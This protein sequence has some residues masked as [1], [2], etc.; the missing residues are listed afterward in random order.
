[1]PGF[2]YSTIAGCAVLATLIAIHLGIRVVIATALVLYALTPFL[3][4][5][6]KKPRYKSGVKTPFSVGGD[7]CLPVQCVLKQA[8]KT[9]FATHCSV[10]TK[11]IGGRGENFRRPGW[12]RPHRPKK[13]LS[14][15]FY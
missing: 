6:K 13:Q 9:G 1:M 15:C 5:R 3:F 7:G 11:V 12:H 10:L 4:P 8:P 2:Q 14:Y